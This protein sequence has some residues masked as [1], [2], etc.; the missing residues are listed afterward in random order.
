MAKKPSSTDV[1][2]DENG[3]EMTFAKELELRSKYI[4]A[5]IERVMRQSHI[6]GKSAA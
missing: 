3:T 1:N 6:R 5:H 4:H 2:L